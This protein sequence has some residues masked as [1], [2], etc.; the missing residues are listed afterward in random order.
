VR[1]ASVVAAVA[2]ASPVLASLDACKAGAAPDR[3]I[4]R[5]AGP[6]PF[7][8]GDGRDARG[9]AANVDSGAPPDDSLMPAPGDALVTRARHL[10]EAVAQDDPTLATDILFPRD[11]WLA[12]RDADDPGKEWDRQVAQPFRRALSTLSRRHPGLDHAQV[13]SLELGRVI[14]QA[15]PRRHAWKKPLWVVGGSRLTFVI[16]GHTRTMAI[17]E[18]VAWRGAWYVTRLL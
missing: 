17:R 4:A 6:T 14:V 13:V 1:A 8:A 9:S 16:D 18:M 10:L 12:T 2:L 15:T 3:A 5:D 7:D 11:G